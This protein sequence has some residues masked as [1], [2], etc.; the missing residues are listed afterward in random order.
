M[1]FKLKSGEPFTFAGLWDSWK[2]PDGTQL[3]TFTII[4]TEP[5]DLL[6]PVHNRMPVILNDD[7]AQVWVEHDGGDLAHA[8]ALLRPF[9][10][11]LMDAYDVSPLV[12]NPRN[13]L[14]ACAVPI[15]E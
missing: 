15:S 3:Q 14:A 10:A 7:D 13:N 6:K 11:D 2:K 1:L 5:N 4:T 9:P 12:N 8:L